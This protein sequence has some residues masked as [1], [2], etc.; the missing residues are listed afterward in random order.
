[1]RLLKNQIYQAVCAIDSADILHKNLRFHINYD[2]EKDGDNPIYKNLVQLFERFKNHELVVH[3]W[4]QHEEFIDVISKIDI[5]LQISYTE[6]FNIVTADFINANTIIV[7]SQS[8]DWMP[9]FFKT[10]TNDYDDT[11]RSIIFGYKVRNSKF[12]KKINKRH[13]EKYN[14]KSKEIW[15]RFLK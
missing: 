13:L 11:I 9:Y 5:G 4:L 12:L 6:S 1:L 14:Y 8:I 15:Q 3:K 7:V 10:S 2:V